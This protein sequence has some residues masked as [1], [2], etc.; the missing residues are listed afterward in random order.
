MFGA[1]FL[2]LIW[3]ARGRGHRGFRSP[4]DLEVC[5]GRARG[6]LRDPRCRT[7]AVRHPTSGRC[8]QN[9]ESE[10]VGEILRFRLTGAVADQRRCLGVSPHSRRRPR[11]DAVKELGTECIECPGCCNGKRCFVS[12]TNCSPCLSK[13]RPLRRPRSLR[14]TS[15]APVVAYWGQCR[16]RA[17]WS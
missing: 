9:R 3:I 7:E 17:N 10:P 2:A 4:V 13:R 8:C 1:S 11:P 16:L 5:D 6:E 14:S 15:R 12:S